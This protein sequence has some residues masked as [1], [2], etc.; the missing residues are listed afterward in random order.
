M[1]TA[2]MT[3]EEETWV[4]EIDDDGDLVQNEVVCGLILWF[5]FKTARVFLS[6]FLS[7]NRFLQLCARI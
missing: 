5:F 1:M 6:F 2:Q 4:A 7:P 3:M